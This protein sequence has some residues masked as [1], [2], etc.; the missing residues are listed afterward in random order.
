M[1]YFS[2][3]N[4]DYSTW[5]LFFNVSSSAFV[6][7]IPSIMIMVLK[8]L[9]YLAL[10]MLSLIWLLV[11]PEAFLCLPRPLLPCPIPLLPC[12]IPPPPPSLQKNTKQNLLSLF[13]LPNSWGKAFCSQQALFRFLVHFCL[14]SELLVTWNGSETKSVQRFISFLYLMVV[15]IAGT[16]NF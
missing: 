16:L 14:S 3:E 5:N 8:Q 2:I 12:P 9:I 13:L 15:W 4:K 7:L 11:G 1:A 10:N 6:F